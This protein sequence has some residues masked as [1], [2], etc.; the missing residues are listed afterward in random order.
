MTVYFYTYTNQSYNLT[1]IQHLVQKNGCDGSVSWMYLAATRK[2]EQVHGNHKSFST[3]TI[4]T[5]ASEWQKRL[6]Q[7]ASVQI[8]EKDERTPDT[9]RYVCMFKNTLQQWFK[10]KGVA[11]F[12]SMQERTLFRRAIRTVAA[13][14]KPLEQQLLSD[15]QKWLEAFERGALQNHQVEDLMLSPKLYQIYV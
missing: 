2:L 12:S 11:V 7:T 4:Q 8:A 14:N 10:R 15:E 5:L 3:G 9:F 1:Q 6:V 13:N